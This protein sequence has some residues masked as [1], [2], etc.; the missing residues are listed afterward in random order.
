MSRKE[1]DQ[2]LEFIHQIDR[3]PTP[4]QVC[5]SLLDTVRPF[6]ITN[7][8]AGTIPITGSTKRQQEANILLHEWPTEWAERYFSNGYLFVDPTIR[9]VTTDTQPFLWSDIAPQYAGNPAATRV[10]N[11]A[12]DFRLN[13]G[14][15]VPLVTLEGEVA[16]FSFA[17]ERLDLPPERHGMLQLL[18]T[19]ALGRAL[20]LEEPPSVILTRREHEVLLWASEGKTEWEIGMILGISEH[21]ADKVFRQARAKLGASNRTHAVAKAIRFGLIN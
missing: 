12:C 18:A 15:T 16:G 6:G 20:V 7:I 5:T 10:M 21:T 19:Y 13:R 17:G 11:E 1:L 14:F 3:A 9:R 2:T 8:L 4:A